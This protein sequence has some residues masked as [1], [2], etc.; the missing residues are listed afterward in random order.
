MATYNGTSGNDTLNAGNGSD[1]LFGG[2]GNDLLSGNGGADT[3]F[4]GAGADT[5]YGGSGTDTADY[6]DSNAAVDVDLATGDG[7]GGHAEGDVLSSIERLVGSDFNDTLTGNSSSNQLTGGAGDDRL[8]GGAGS[9]SLYG[10]EGAD[11]LIGGTGSDTLEGGAGVDTADYSASTSG[12][13]VSLGSGTWLGLDLLGNDLGFL[14]SSLGTGYG[15][16]A[17][18]DRLR[19]IENLLGSAYADTLTGNEANNRLEG[20]AGSDYLSGGEGND[21]LIGGEGADTLIGGEDMDYVDYSDSNAAVSINLSNNTASGG[22]AAGDVLSGVDGVFGSAFN[23]TIIGF[24]NQG[25]SGDIYTNV[26][27]GAA[28]DDYI[29][30]RG[31]DDQVYGGVGNDTVLGGAGNDSLWGDAGN[32][33]V[34]GGDGQD[35]LDGGAGNDLLDGGSGNDLLYGGAG[36]DTL[37]GG[38]GNDALLGDDGNDSLYGGPGDDT[39]DGGAGNDWLEA[40]DGNDWL[41]GGAG[42]DTLVGGAGSDFLTGGG[43]RDFIYAGLGDTIDGGEAGDDIDTL[44]L[45]GLGPHRIIRDPLNGENG[46]VQFLDSWGNVTGTITF[47][48]IENIVACFTP[49]TAIVT[50]RG[51]VAVENLRPGQRVMTR[52]HGLQPIRWVGQRRL[53]IGE[54]IADPALQPVRIRKGALGQGLPERDML[55]SRQHR[56]L[57]TGQRAELM[58]GTDEVLVRAIHLVGQPGIECAALREV[59]YI[60]LLFDRHELVLG[61]GAWSE[62]FQPGDRSLAGLDCPTRDEVVKLFP[63]LATGVLPRN[64]EAARMTLK[65]HEARA[66]LRV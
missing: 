12:V 14:T 66:L 26:L 52:D 21:T 43:D 62:S 51:E 20:G 39:L 46:V 9:D 13:N 36:N 8:D 16:D 60:H 37:S 22:H 23:D 6:S 27:Y 53:G 29:D 33:L 34:Y 57:V 32:D 31:S 56:M 28:G 61:D 49:G 24:D 30:A 7:H 55:V 17:N 18:G 11:T 5:L 10:G 38:A 35:N 50:D 41:Y 15:G 40:G 47:L 64:F 44:D 1:S 19:D 58:F 63:D 25:L 2:A 4:G 42:E 45:T 48:N 65:S 54:L 59:T 3:L